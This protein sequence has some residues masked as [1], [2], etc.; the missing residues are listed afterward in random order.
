M[1][2]VHVWIVIVSAMAAGCGGSSPTSPAGSGGVGA[3]GTVLLE[4][5]PLNLSALDYAA[6]VANRAGRDPDWLPFV[7]FGVIG[8]VSSARP[9]PTP[10]VQPV[11]YAPLGTPVMAIVSGVI[12][13]VTLLYSSDYSVMIASPDG[14]GGIWEHEHVINVRVKVGDTVAAGQPIGD[15]SNYE[16][17]WGRNNLATDPVCASHLG[18]VEIGLLYG[19]NPP[20]HR[21]PFDPEVVSP[22][23]RDGIFAAL[24][25]ARARIEAAFGDPSKYNGV[26]RASSQCVTLERV[27][28]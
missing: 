28:G 24:D 17:A 1:R 23:K 10:D 13:R 4:G 18:L 7:D 16:C 12:S 15:V 2:A 21:C 22:S 20:S 27:P 19:G 26:S 14:K 9:N 6:I 3:D 11:F 25:A 5:L 8:T